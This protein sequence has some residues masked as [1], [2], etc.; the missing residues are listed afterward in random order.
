LPPAWRNPAPT[1]NRNDGFI[2]SLISICVGLLPTNL[3]GEAVTAIGIPISNT[4]NVRVLNVHLGPTTESKPRMMG[5]KTSPPIPAPE[6]MNPIADPR[7][8][9]KYSGAVLRMG[10]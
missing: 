9:V 5:E 2:A 10:K 6:R 4:K 3:D 8:V 1:L 7:C